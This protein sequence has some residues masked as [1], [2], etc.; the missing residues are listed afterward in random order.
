[1]IGQRRFVVTA[2]LASL[3]ACVPAPPTSPLAM[4]QEL[5]TIEN[6]PGPFCGRCDTM[7]VTASS[8]GRVWIEHGYWAGHYTDWT[9]ERRLERVPISNFLRFRDQLARYRPR[10]VLALNQKPPCETFWND[11]DGARVEWRDSNR[12]DKLFLNFGC[13]P[14]GK[15]IIAETVRAAPD[16]LGISTLKMPW[17]QWVATSLG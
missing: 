7:K 8:D 16:L 12:D 4:G 5:I 13:D 6:E 11:I 1:M 10:G 15:R 2:A 17:G 9:K 3:T 14:D